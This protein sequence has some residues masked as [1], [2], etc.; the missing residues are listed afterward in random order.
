M[1]E[2]VNPKSLLF[3]LLLTAWGIGKRRMAQW[4]C[5]KKKKKRRSAVGC[6][7]NGIA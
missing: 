6:R 4:H 2:E 3:R 1:D 7:L 5:F